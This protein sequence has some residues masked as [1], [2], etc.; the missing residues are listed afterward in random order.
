MHSVDLSLFYTIFSVSGRS[1]WLDWSVLFFGEYYLYILFV[2]FGYFLYKEIRNRRLNGL[3]GYFFAGI[4]AITARFGVAELIRLFYHRPRPFIALHLKHLLTDYAYSF[5]SG[6]TIF[7]FAL[8]TGVF[9]VNRK[10]AYFL[11]ASGVIVGLA[12]IAGGVHYPSDIVG[13]A[14]LG[15]LTSYLLY[16][17][18]LYLGRRINISIIQKWQ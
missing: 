8:A 1:T 6:H 10:F 2:I 16:Q 3:Y 17:V 11:Y 18:W 7:I 13:G 12:R 15:I 5:P 4:A 9:F 14:I